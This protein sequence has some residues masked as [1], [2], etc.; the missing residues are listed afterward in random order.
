M[1]MN[2]ELV[3]TYMKQEDM[4]G[5]LAFGPWSSQRE[6]LYR[7]ARKRRAKVSV[8]ERAAG[9]FPAWDTLP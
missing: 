7:K 4:S 1:T 3:P 6:R 9:G 8:Y 2:W 5:V